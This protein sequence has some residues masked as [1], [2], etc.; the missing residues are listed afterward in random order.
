MY[1]INRNFAI[2]LAN[3]RDVPALRE[4]ITASVQTLHAPYYSP[5]QIN[6]ALGPVFGVD[7]QLIRDGTY[8]VVER[9]GRIV[10]CGGWSYRQTVFGGDRGKEGGGVAL[11]PGSDP[12]RIRAFFVHPERAR[13]GIGRLLLERCE[14]AMLSAGFREALLVATLAGEP[15]YRAAGYRVERRFEVPLSDGLTLPVVRMSKIVG[16]S[17]ETQ[18]D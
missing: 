18:L 1:S 4:L 5:S 3:D 2:R 13:C 6:A 12:A 9:E 15:F 10:G 17:P 7:S 11:V 14:S 16:R 8:F